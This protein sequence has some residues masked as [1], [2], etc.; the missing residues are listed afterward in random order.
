[1]ILKHNIFDIG[2][3]ITVDNDFCLT[4]ENKELQNFWISS[5]VLYRNKT[6]KREIYKD[7]DAIIFVIEGRGV[8]EQGQE[9]SYIAANDMVFLTKGSDYRIINNGDIHLKFLVIKEKV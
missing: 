8:F 3:I 4:T 6:T 7:T 2:G 5:T 1:M 9:I